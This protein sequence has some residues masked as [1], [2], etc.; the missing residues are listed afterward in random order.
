M[1]NKY[2]LMEEMVWV[3]RAW[4]ERDLLMFSFLSGHYV[5]SCFTF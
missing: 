2:W 3:L 1:T 4:F 5:G